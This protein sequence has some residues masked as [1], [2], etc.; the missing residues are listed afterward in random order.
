M[1][2]SFFLGFS[3]LFPL[4]IPKKPR[5]LV[6][7]KSR[8][9]S[10]HRAKGSKLPIAGAAQPSSLTSRLGGPWLFSLPKAFF[11]A[12]ERNMPVTLTSS[13]VGSTR[14]KDVIFLDLETLDFT[15]P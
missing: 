4:Q 13:C 3:R 7:S 12:Y 9:T 2:F 6:K 11:W 14:P 1:F 8:A 10:P 5:F 15:L